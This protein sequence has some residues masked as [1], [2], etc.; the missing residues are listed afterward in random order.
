MRVY[1]FRDLL[2]TWPF[3][4]LNPEKIP[5]CTILED[6]NTTVNKYFWGLLCARN[7]IKTKACGSKRSVGLYLTKNDALQ[8]IYNVIEEVGHVHT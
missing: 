5:Y 7:Q 4:G 6:K 8:R 3:S 1:S 2:I